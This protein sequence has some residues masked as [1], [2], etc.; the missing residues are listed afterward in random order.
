M[1]EIGLLHLMLEI[2]PLFYKMQYPG[3]FNRIIMALSFSTFF[4]ILELSPSFYQNLQT[5]IHVP[6]S[7]PVLQ[8]VM[9][10]AI[11]ECLLVTSIKMSFINE[12][13]EY[14]K[15]KSQHHE[16]NQNRIQAEYQPGFNISWRQ[17]RHRLRKV[18]NIG[19]QGSEYWD[20]GGGGFMLQAHGNS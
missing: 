17:G 7:I 1:A 5:Y 15:V 16:D 8:M 6:T 13:V 18:L 9:A 14:G 10:S 19:G 20:G 4:L 2:M 3:A 11:S 12:K